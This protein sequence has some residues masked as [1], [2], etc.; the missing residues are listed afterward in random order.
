MSGCSRAEQRFQ[1]CCSQTPMKP[2]GV[3]FKKTSPLTALNMAREFWNRSKALRRQRGDRRF[4]SG[5]P[6]HE[7]LATMFCSRGREGNAPHS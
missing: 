5:Q 1:N 4:N 3:F 6:L 7:Y 2:S